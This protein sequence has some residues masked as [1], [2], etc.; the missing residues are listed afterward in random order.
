MHFTPTAARWL[1]SVEKKLKMCSWA[2]FRQL[3]LNRF[4]RD[5]HELLVRQPLNIKQTGSVVEYIDNFAALMD[6]LAA[7]DSHTDPLYFTM[8]FIDGLREDLRAP[9][10]IQRPSSLDTAYVLAQ[11]QDEVSIGGRR[12]EF[13]RTEFQHRP[14]TTS[15]WPLPPPPKLDKP[16]IPIAEDHRQLESARGRSVEDRLSALRAYRRAQGL[17]QHCAEKWS[18]GHRCSDKVQLNALQEV[19]DL[20]HLSDDHQPSYTSSQAGEQLFLTL[21]VA[22]VSG[23]SAPRTMCIQGKIQNQCMR[24]LVDSGSSNTFISEQLASNLCGVTPIADDISV[25]VDD[26]NI[27]KFSAS[28]PH[29]LWSYGHYEFYSD[30]KV[31]PLSSYDMIFGLDWLE[32]FSPMKVHWKQKWLAIPYKGSVAVLCG[33]HSK[34]P[35]GSVIQVCQVEITAADKV[36][37][38]Y[39][40]EVQQLLADFA[41]LFELPTKLP[42]ARSCDHSIPLVEGAALFNIRQ[43]R[44][45]PALKNE[46]EQQV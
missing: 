3:L 36:D 2:E 22:A 6:Q 31:L 28:I 40:T 18:K 9:M 27:I 17:C 44:Y 19:L 8:R 15:G 32:Q 45:P 12:K 1:P 25:R 37:I 39:P 24:I 29:C 38:A 7:Y 21:S 14:S 10:L 26:G 43:Y 13:K 41:V 35:E 16:G 30:L 20:F 46:I 11:L 5:Q 23:L 33:E 34:L 4:G 42:H